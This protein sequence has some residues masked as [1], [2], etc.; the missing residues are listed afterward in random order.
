L[1]AQRGYVVGCRY[2]AAS[3]R[4]RGE[5]AE[6][7]GVFSHPDYLGGE[8]G[9]PP[10]GRMA[11]T[12]TR[13]RCLRRPQPEVTAPHRQEAW[14][15]LFTAGVAP[16]GK[17]LDGRIL[18]FAA[19]SGGNRALHHGRACAAEA[20]ERVPRHVG[21]RSRRRDV[22]YAGERTSTSN[23]DT[24]RFWFERFTPAARAPGT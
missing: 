23:R 4:H 3:R 19:G 10:R 20:L 2:G 7:T 9:R 18:A 6:Y 22:H 13:A 16:A 1:F 5:F 8:T 11:G 15:D 17:G 24:T 12:S 14:V 21:R